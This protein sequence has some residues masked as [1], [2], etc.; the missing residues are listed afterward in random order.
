M[1]AKKENQAHPPRLACY[2]LA[3]ISHDGLE[4]PG[5]TPSQTVIIAATDWLSVYVCRYSKS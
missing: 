2:G 3:P 1:E 4:L 5:K